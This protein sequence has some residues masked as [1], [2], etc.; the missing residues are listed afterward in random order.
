VHYGFAGAARIKSDLSGDRPPREMLD[1]ALGPE[2]VEAALRVREGLVGADEGQRGL[3]LCHGFCELGGYELEPTLRA[4]RDF[5]IQNPA[6][7][8]LLIIEDYVT[9][10]DLARAFERSGLTDL[11]YSGPAPPWPTLGELVTSGQRVIVFIESGKPG[12]GWLR[13][14]FEHIQETPYSFH[15]P[16]EFSCEP[17][18]GGQS[19]SLF[20][21][22]HWIES[23]PTPQPSNAAIVN[24]YDFLLRRV[25]RCERERKHL[26]NIIAVDFYRTGGLFGVVDSLNARGRGAD[27]P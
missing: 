19:G 5:L 2:G 11:V 25:R 4:I 14:A 15:S 10:E 27:P 21:I 22:N 9:P 7:V 18:R 20:Q 12:V 6:E 13:P 8:L 17:N 26:P 16:E 23:T 3:Y 24:E 1:Q